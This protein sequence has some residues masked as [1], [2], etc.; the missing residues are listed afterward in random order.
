MQ[1]TKYDQRQVI[2]YSNIQFFPQKK[3]NLAHVISRLHTEYHYVY[4]YLLVLDEVD[5]V[6]ELDTV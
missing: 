5:E 3:Y 2:V 4:I 6:D 1:S